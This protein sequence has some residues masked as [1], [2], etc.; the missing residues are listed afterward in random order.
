MKKIV[1]SIG[2]LAIGAAAVQGVGAMDTS[3]T[4]SVGA[5]LRG[6]YDDNY[7]TAPKGMEQESFGMSV[8]P[9]VGLNLPM[10]RTDISLRY[11][12][13][14]YWYEDRKNN[15]WDHT[16]QF[17]GRL[18]HAFSERH[19]L[20]VMDS[21]VIA[22][23]PQV[24][25]PTGL[26]QNPFR[27][28]GDNM[29]N[30]FVL[31]LNSQL[32]E[33][34]SSVLGYRNTWFDFE[35]DR[36]ANETAFGF[37]LNG[38]APT[39]SAI[40]D[41]FEHTFLLN[42]RWQVVQETVG[43]IGYDYAITKY[44]SDEFIG[45]IG[46]PWTG[47]YVPADWRDRRSHFLY[48]GV[49]HNFSPRMLLSVRVGAQ[50]ADFHNDPTSD[51]SVTPYGD[52]SLSYVYKAGSNLRVGVSHMRSHTDIIAPVQTPAPGANDQ[53]TSDQ[54]AT[55]LYGM[56][57]HAFTPRLTGTLSGHYQDSTFEGGGYDSQS[58]AFFGAS[59]GLS[60]KINRHWF[61]DVGYSFSALDSDIRFREYD[62]NRFFAGVSAVF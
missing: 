19:S 23:E 29:R 11:T 27:V 39:H 46:D 4:W 12:F 41:R 20:Y 13:G 18:N 33:K 32:T 51:P 8:A 9:W 37:L 21:F 31:H 50:D 15:E 44:T 47:V 38:L 26:T 53:I 35:K 42:L 7:L 16:H 17:D 1:A 54:Q 59:L 2:T 62:R 28:E 6:F 56:V 34:W 14:A 22:Q 36:K 48:A 61:A 3:R 60:Y 43:V 25:D 24:L 57:T 30:H 10:E 49:D 5:S 40:H 55:V 45:V 58:E 52:V